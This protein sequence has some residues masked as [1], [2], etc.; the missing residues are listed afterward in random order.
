MPIPENGAVLLDRRGV[1]KITGPDARD[2]L[3]G[4]VTNDMNKVHADR[5]I[6]AALLTPQ[7]KFLFDF[8]IAEHDGA[9][10]MD[11]NGE[12][13]HDLVKRLNM[14]KLRADVDVEDVT[15]RIAVYGFIGSAADAVTPSGIAD[16]GTAWAL[17]DSVAFIDPRLK[18]MGVRALLSRSTGEEWIAQQGLD[19]LDQ[20]AYLDLRM[21]LG[22]P[23]GGTDIRADKAF[24]LESNFDELHGVDHQ[25]GCYIGQETTSRTKRRGLI[26]KRLL[27]IEF[28][29]EAPPLGTPI[30]AGKIELG[31]VFS[32][33]GSRA[34][35]LIRLDRLDEIDVASV[36]AEG[37]HVRIIKP[38][39]IFKPIS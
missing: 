33:A 5:A 20:S 39:W 23:E 36:T 27:P 18:D 1:L 37:K 4:L 25:K 29:G 34:I 22:V 35:A 28:D 32:G 13:R 11:C 24:L 21:A 31:T 14:Y 17:S 7:G 38:D 9:L 12:Q 26:R 8:F 19:R 2:F 10:F 6:Y 30:Q 3:Q 16:L 15:E